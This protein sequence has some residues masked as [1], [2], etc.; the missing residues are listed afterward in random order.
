MLDH[1]TEV[2]PCFPTRIRLFIPFRRYV[3]F[4][5][6]LSYL[7]D[8]L[9]QPFQ[10]YSS[11]SLSSPVSLCPSPISS[12]SSHAQPIHPCLLNAIYL[13]GSCFTG[14]SLA[15]R[16]APYFLS[17]TQKCLYASLQDADRLTHFLWASVI[18]STCQICIGRLNEAF[19][20]V[21]SAAGIATACGL[22][23]VWSTSSEYSPAGDAVSPERRDRDLE[24]SCLLSRAIHQDEIEDRKSLAC[25]VFMVDR[26]LSLTWGFPTSFKVKTSNMLNSRGVYGYSA[27]LRA[28][29]LGRNDFGL[30]SSCRWIKKEQD[31]VAEFKYKQGG[32]LDIDRFLAAESPVRMKAIQ[33]YERV[34]QLALDIQSRCTTIFFSERMRA[35]RLPIF[36]ISH[37][38]RNWPYELDSSRN[39]CARLCAL[40]ISIDTSLH[41][42]QIYNQPR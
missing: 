32:D 37:T 27:I 21:S 2:E 31:V 10:C 14:S 41:H 7:F 24:S 6:D 4:Q 35:P 1:V 12:C 42:R 18:L 33:L 16:L 11:S 5:M 38:R 15:T 3:H 17:Q 22:D 34:Q 28:D 13:A 36:T 26:T 29:V 40:H 8:S 19:G 39:H 30:V 20:G 23:L 9:A 25:A